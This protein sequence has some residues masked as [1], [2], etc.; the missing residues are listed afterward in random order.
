M[1]K[2]VRLRLKFYSYFIDDRTDD[3]KV[4]DRKKNVERTW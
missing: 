4:K 2:I 1:L 3:K